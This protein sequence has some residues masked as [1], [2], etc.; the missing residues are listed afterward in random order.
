MLPKSVSYRK[1]TDSTDVLAVGLEQSD[2]LARRRKGGTVGYI[3][4]GLKGG[5]RLV[6]EEG[7]PT[8]QPTWI[9]KPVVLA[10][11]VE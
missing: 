10:N 9:G 11:Q 8:N 7:M 4:G 6:V 1:N 5:M 2:E 3:V